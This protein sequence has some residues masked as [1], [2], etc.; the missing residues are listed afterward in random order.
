[1]LKQHQAVVGQFQME[2]QSRGLAYQQGRLNNINT[3]PHYMSGLRMFLR[4][5][6]CTLHPPLHPE[7]CIFFPLFFTEV[8]IVERLVLQTSYVLNNKILQ[9]WGTKSAV[10][11]QK[12]FQIKSGLQWP[13]IRQ[14]VFQSHTTSE[15]RN[16]KGIR[17]KQINVCRK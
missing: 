6:T 7:V 8:Y 13:R 12:R 3:P 17:D 5:I 11:N 16:M 4:C 15:C 9:F 14:L 10:C 1:M 2:A